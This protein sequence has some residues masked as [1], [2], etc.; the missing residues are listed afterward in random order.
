MGERR[1]AHLA[2]CLRRAAHHRHTSHRPSIV[3]PDAVSGHPREVHPHVARV[4]VRPATGLTPYG[5]A[6]GQLTAQAAGTT[7]TLTCFMIG[8]SLWVL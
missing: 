2:A 5:R 4:H 1:T 6:A 8:W 3:P 7:V